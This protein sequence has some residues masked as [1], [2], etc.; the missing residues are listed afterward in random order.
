MVDICVLDDVELQAAAQL[1]EL[2]P[3]FSA[4]L[5]RPKEVLNG[6]FRKENQGGIGS[7]NGAAWSAL[8]E[9]VLY[10]SRRDGSTQLSKLWMYLAAQAQGGLL[11]HDQGSRPTDGG[12]V[13]L[14]GICPETVVPYPQ[15]ALQG[16][17]PDKSER[18]RILSAENA[19]AGEQYRVAQIWRKPQSHA[20][21]L[22]LIGLSGGGWVFGI[23]WYDGLIPKDRIVRSYNPR[24]KRILGGHAMCC[25]GYYA[26]ENL[27]GHNSHNDPPYQIEP[28]AWEQML[29][30]PSTSVVGATGTEDARPVDW[31]QNSPWT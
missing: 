29:A 8:G 23:T 12:K 18:T 24:G 5:A 31:L 10:A 28:Q 9:R 1:P 4:G 2:P 16:I 27:E 7:C 13:A 30:H 25:L 19:R 21:T 11:G 17:Y 22:D 14:K 20:E 3:K 6:W 15:Y 26:N